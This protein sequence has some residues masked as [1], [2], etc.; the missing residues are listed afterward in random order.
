MTVFILKENKHMSLPFEETLYMEYYMKLRL[1]NLSILPLILFTFGGVYSILKV[2][3]MNNQLYN[4]IFLTRNEK[5]NN[6]NSIYIIWLLVT[7]MNALAC[8]IGSM[9]LGYHFVNGFKAQYCTGFDFERTLK[10]KY[11]DQIKSY[12]DVDL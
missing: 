11:L 4:Y 3:R 8:S 2:K 10:L 1:H 9:I 5:K 12:R 7:G 6:I